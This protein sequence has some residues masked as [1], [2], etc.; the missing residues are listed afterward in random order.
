[1]KNLRKG[2]AFCASRSHIVAVRQRLALSLP[3]LGVSSL[4]LGRSFNRVALFCFSDD[5]IER[6]YSAAA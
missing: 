3:S 5:L 4:D 2:L 1:M 6:D